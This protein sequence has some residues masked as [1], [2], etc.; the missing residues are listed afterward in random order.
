M[1]KTTCRLALAATF[2]FLLAAGPAWAERTPE[3]NQSYETFS[4]LLKKSAA[5]VKAP[6]GK[7]YCP[8]LTETYYRVEKAGS[9]FYDSECPASLRQQMG[10]QALLFRRSIRALRDKNCKGK[11]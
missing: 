2:A 5:R 10:T 9:K 8:M 11:E 6:R 3:C 7:D 4:T 1:M